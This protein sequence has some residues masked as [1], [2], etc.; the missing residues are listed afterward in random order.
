MLTDAEHLALLKIRHERALAFIEHMQLR[1]EYDEW[2]AKANLAS[3][4]MT[5][6]RGGGLFRELR[7]GID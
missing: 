4:F 7:E 2:M 3:E 5:Q 6:P 1:I